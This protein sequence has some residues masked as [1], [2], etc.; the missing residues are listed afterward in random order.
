MTVFKVKVMAV[1]PKSTEKVTP[2]IEVLVD[3]GA[4]VTWLPRDL[5]L[6]IAI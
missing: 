3:T 6:Q 5:L 2:P 1:N 4:E